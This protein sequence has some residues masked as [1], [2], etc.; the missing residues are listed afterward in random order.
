MTILQCQGLCRL[1]FK[2]NEG[3]PL[4]LTDT[5][6]LIFLAIYEKKWYRTLIMCFTRYGKSLVVALAVLLRTA[7]YPEK[8][9]IVAGSEGKAK[10]IMEYIIQHIYDNAYFIMKFQ[11]EKGE[12]DDE[13]RRHRNKARI[14]FSLGDGLLGEIYICSAKSALGFG[15]PNVVLDESALITDEEY[16]MVLRM[17]GDSTENF[18][19]EISNPMMRNHFFEAYNNPEYYKINVDCYKGLIEGRI[20]EHFI[21][22]QKQRNKLF[23]QLYL[24]IFP[25]ENAID[26]KGWFNLFYEEEIKAAQNVIEAKG[27]PRLGVDVGHGGDASVWT[28][29]WINYGMI[30]REDH[31]DN[32]HN[33][34]RKTEFWMDKLK[35]PDFNVFV[36]GTGLGI[37]VVDYLQKEK[38]RMI[39]NV[40]LG[41]KS[42]DPDCFNK[43]AECFS[44]LSKWIKDG[45]NL[46]PDKRWD[47][48]LCI[49][50]KINHEKKLQ[51]MSK[52]EMRKNHIDSPNYADSLALTCAVNDKMFY[53]A[54]PVPTIADKQL[55]EFRAEQRQQNNSY[56]KQ[57]I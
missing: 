45:G 26:D 18:L 41:S 29:R 31:D 9:A 33:I 1:L 11:K 8:W 51:V 3:K 5:Q 40:M 50:V 7:T 55:K 54:K 35:I 56:Q 53:I 14:N 15:A 16:A 27:I 12:T 34:G 19:C 36:D 44:N 39:H 28:L 48:L 57:I 49:K 20:T 6:A 22:E 13:I 24:N 4:E 25:E 47:E 52:D 2:D 23:N 32:L 37:G 46:K 10:I 42:N 17:L 38:K 21:E 43:R 30:L